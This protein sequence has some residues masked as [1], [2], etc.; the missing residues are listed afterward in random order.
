[1]K[2]HVNTPLKSGL[3][4]FTLGF[5]GVISALPLIP[6]LLALQPE[7]PPIPL[8]LLQILSTLQSSVILGGLIALG[9]YCAPKVALDAPIIRGYLENKNVSSLLGSI[10][11]PAIVGGTLGAI[12]IMAFWKMMETHLP[13]SFLANAESFLPPWYT[14]LLYGGITEELLIRWGLMSFF[15]WL[16]FK[17]TQKNVGPVKAYNYILANLVTALL[18]GLAHLPVASLLSTEITPA[19]VF[20]IITGNAIFGLIAGWL[21]WRK[22]IECAIVAHMVCHL[23]VMFIQLMAS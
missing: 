8:F 4:L 3:V 7:Q 1:M 2:A 19:L 18:F 12:L 13:Q 21:F 11:K 20:Y 22:G 15:V 23:G 17:Y 6:Q 10:I 9:L 14:R 5:V 16:T